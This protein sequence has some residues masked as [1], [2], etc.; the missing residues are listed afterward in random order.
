MIRFFKRGKAIVGDRFPAI[1]DESIDAWA[2]ALPE[3]HD[4]QDHNLD[5]VIRRWARTGVDNRMASPKSIL[6]A[7]QEERKAWANTPEGR[8]QLRAHRRRMEDL[9]DRQLAD[10]TFA[11]IRGIRN[12]EIAGPSKPENLHDIKQQALEKIRQGQQRF[13]ETHHD[14]ENTQ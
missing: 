4:M 5:A 9:R 13:K 7:I 10:G 14:T 1:T 3:V 12:R 8:A 2:R 11:Q 6:A